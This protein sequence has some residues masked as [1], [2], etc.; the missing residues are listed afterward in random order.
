[1]RDSPVFFAHARTAMV[2]G[3]RLCNISKD[4]VVLIPDYICS[5]VPQSISDVCSYVYYPVNN[6]FTPDWKKLN[7]LVGDETKAIMMVHYFGQA[8]DVEKFIN[9]AKE[10]SLLLIEDNS[11]GHSGLLNGQVL[12]TYG[13]IG[14]SSP[15]KITRTNTGGI[16]YLNHDLVSAPYIMKLAQSNIIKNKFRYIINIFPAIKKTL[17][18]LFFKNPD[19]A[20]PYYFKESSV[21]EYRADSY[22]ENIIKSSNWIKIAAERRNRWV[23]WVDFAL[24]NGLQPVWEKPDTNSCPWAVPVY[25]TNKNERLFWLNW[26]R[27]HGYDIFPWPSLETRVILDSENCVNR[28]K[29]LLCFPLHQQPPK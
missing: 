19:Y 4:D 14:F 12:G 22:S 8:Q 27:Y 2:H 16:L 10:Y 3:L 11:H 7:E 20:D 13:D 5:V 25:A 21:K 15:R 1:M 23:R 28:W 24:N 9:F 6:D 17:K 29:H 26:G 18:K